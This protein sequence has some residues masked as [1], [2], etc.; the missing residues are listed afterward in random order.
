MASETEK[1]CRTQ[2]NMV[3]VY[4]IFVLKCNN[5][6]KYTW[7]N[8]NENRHEYLKD[9]IWWLEWTDLGYGPVADVMQ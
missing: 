1:S 2:G 7:N 8:N 9:E 5:G 6:D 3:T 4:K